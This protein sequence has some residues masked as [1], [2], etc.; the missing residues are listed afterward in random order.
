MAASH[1]LRDLPPGLYHLHPTSAD[2]VHRLHTA[3]EQQGRSCLIFPSNVADYLVTDTVRC[4][5]A[6]DL[7]NQGLTGGP[8]NAK[9]DEIIRGSP[10]R[11]HLHQRPTTLSG[12]E[13]QLL[14]ITTAL[15]Q[16]YEFLIG[17]HC[18]DFVS[19]RNIQIM[20]DHLRAQGKRMLEVTYRN[21]QPGQGRSFWR[22]DGE[23]LESYPAARWDV[24]V[25]DWR[26]TIPPWRLKAQQVEKRFDDSA[27]TLHI[28][29]L[30]LD[31]VR[32][33]GIFGDNG[34]GKSTLAD[35]LTGIKPYSGNLAMELPGVDSPRL[36]YLVQYAVP[37]THG[38]TINDII[39]RFIRQG[40]LTEMQGECL[41]HTLSEAAYYQPLAG[42][43]AHIGYRLVIVAALL[44][45]DYDLVILDEPTYGLPTEAVAT[46]LAQGV[47]DLGAKPLA[48]ISHDRHF[49]T[50]FCDT[51]IRLD[52]GVVHEPAI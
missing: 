9:V 7:E 28:P 16:P 12:G 36:G 19:A 8:L 17:Q 39:Q 42:L 30:V 43:D 31:R 13:Q 1:L 35:C 25:P 21:G 34:S 23:R 15:Q 22:F 20:H 6:F 5:A 46:F 24:A 18:F 48:I 41:E 47:G 45:G 14:A 32:C 38:L 51:I 29:R 33:L 44:M 3:L 27:F 4:E 40:R 2:F 50:P 52:N 10:L 11:E 37:P 26:S 49:L